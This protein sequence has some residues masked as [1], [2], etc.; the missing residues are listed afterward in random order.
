MPVTSDLT[1]VTN[2]EEIPVA[3]P[4]AP[5]ETEQIEPTQSVPVPLVEA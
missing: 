5:S 2:M 4:P 1:P 3:V